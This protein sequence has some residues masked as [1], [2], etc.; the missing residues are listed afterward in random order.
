MQKT[1]VNGANGQGGRHEFVVAMIGWER[2]PRLQALIDAAASLDIQLQPVPTGEV[3]WQQLRQTPIDG[4]L[5][6]RRVGLETIRQICAWVQLLQPVPA[7]LV[8]TAID[9]GEMKAALHAGADAV[10][11]ASV[12]VSVIAAQLFALLR[13]R[14]TIG[15]RGETQFQF[16]DLTVDLASRRVMA[17]GTA[18]PLTNLEFAVV[19]ALARNAGQVLSSSRIYFEASGVVLLEGEARELMKAHVR[20]IRAKLEALGVSRDLIQ[21]VRGE[22]YMIDRPKSRRLQSTSPF[23]T[24]I[25]IAPAV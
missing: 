24:P 9:D 19:A 18:V 7:V 16:R 4:L 17:N 22:G 12:D 23:D 11:P 8:V 20:R 10:A 15:K 25:M 21:N 1:T 5:L 2:L 3:A 14:T 13:R 6:E